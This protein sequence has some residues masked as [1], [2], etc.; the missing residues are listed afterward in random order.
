MTEHLKHIKIEGFKSIKALDLNM[1][2]LNVLIGA[3]GAG[4]SNFISIFTFLRNLSRGKLQH[5]TKVHGGADNFFHFGNKNTS[6]INLK[7][8]VGKNSYAA[9]LGQQPFDDEFIILEEYCG[10]FSSERKYMHNENRSESELADASKDPVVDYTKKYLDKCRVYHFHDTS[11]S[12]AFKKTKKLSSNDYLHEDAA[13]IA[14]FLYRLKNNYPYSYNNIVRTIRSI[15]PFFHD[16]YLEPSGED[17]DQS[18]LLKWLHEEYDEP[19]SAQQL[20]D[21]T[22]RFICMAT[23][24]LQPDTLAP[25]TVII[26]EPELGLHPAAIEVLADIINACSQK[27]MQII[28]STQSVELANYFKPE[29]FIVVDYDKGVSSFQRLELD[30][31]EHWLDDYGMGDIWAKNLI[32]GRP[33]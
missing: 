16:F 2:S 30:Q 6:E 21:G 22:A 31:V 13:N 18:I 15:A 1:K 9:I 19:F 26:D 17:E 5:L 12:A 8:D 11:T 7:V 33:E 32:G 28:C 3:N 29:D 4:K 14:P 10:I 23:L 25:K 20:S 27:N 24:F